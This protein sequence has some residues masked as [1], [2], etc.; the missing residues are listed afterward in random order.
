MGKPMLALVL[1]LALAGCEDEE[2]PRFEVRSPAFG[3]GMT[4]PARHSCEGSDISPPLTLHGLPDLDEEV[5]SIAVVMVDP[6]APLGTYVHWVEWNIPG[7]ADFIA[8][9][10]N[11]NLPEGAFLG[12]GSGE[13]HLGYRGPCPPEGER[14]RYYFRVY[15]LD[16][17]L[18]L[19]EGSSRSAL[20]KAM[21]GHVVGEGVLMGRYKK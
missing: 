13:D 7:D 15:A 6:D 8:E 21:K 18:E 19:A 9:D 20:D 1:A 16:K 4:I 14:H 12:E 10:Q 2:P 3:E 5:E 17:E 11:A